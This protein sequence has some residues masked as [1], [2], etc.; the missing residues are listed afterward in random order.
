MSMT[1]EEKAKVYAGELRVSTAIPGV[2]IPMIADM[3]EAAYLAG[4][5]PK[6]LPRSG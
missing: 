3:V 6:P 2:V 5:L 4:A 1:T